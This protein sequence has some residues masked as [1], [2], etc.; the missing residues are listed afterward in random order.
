MLCTLSCLLFAAVVR[1]TSIAAMPCYLTFL[2]VSLHTV[3]W[4]LWLVQA[5]KTDLRLPAL[6]RLCYKAHCWIASCV[7][8]VCHEGICGCIS[9]TSSLILCAF[10]C[11]TESQEWR[12]ARCHACLQQTLAWSKW[13]ILL[14]GEIQGPV[15]IKSA[16]DSPV[17]V[18]P[19]QRSDFFLAHFVAWLPTGSGHSR[20]I[21]HSK[22]HF[23]FVCVAMHL[24]QVFYLKESCWLMSYCQYSA[25]NAVC[26]CG[27]CHIFVVDPVLVM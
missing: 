1:K 15:P 7:S 20:A 24:R 21:C 11:Q 13:E 2:K 26:F 8:N 10:L 14:E 18:L 9:L 12:V 25:L 6:Q 22:A 4:L 23:W 5:V 19:V 3:Y 17:L 16:V 27:L